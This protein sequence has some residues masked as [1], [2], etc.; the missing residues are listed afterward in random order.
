MREFVTI[1]EPLVAYSAQEVNVPLDQVTDFS[2]YPAGAELNVTFGLTRLGRQ[3]TYLTALGS[4]NNGEFLQHALSAEQIDTE[5]IKVDP[6]APTGIYFKE[7][8]TAGDPQIEY[9]R[10]NTAASRLQLADLGE[11]DF[12]KVKLLHLTGIAAAISPTMFKNIEELILIAR[13]NDTLISFD[14]NI[15]PALW[16]SA[17]QMKRVL[18]R[19]AGQCDIVLPGLGEGRQLTGG[20][21]AS[22]IADFY[23]NL[24]TPKLVVVK[25]GSTGAYAKDEQGTVIESAAFQVDQV[26]DTVGAG[27]GFAAGLLSG[28]LAQLPLA[29][30]LRRANAMGAFAV[31]SE[32]DNSG[33]PDLA[34]LTTFLANN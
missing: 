11:L 8:V 16:S 22:E 30:S 29:E 19:I 15:R 10:K 5:Q 7:R 24:A 4:D 31:Q 6:E 20:K 14:P 17:E 13:Q 12:S 26:V 18:N 34:R 23:L 21:T 1:G 25:N 3:C 9:A 27:D 32:G 33:Y 28:I 2:R